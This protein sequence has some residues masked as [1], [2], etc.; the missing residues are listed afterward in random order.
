MKLIAT[1]PP[2]APHAEEI[3]EHPDVFALRFNT[4]HPTPWSKRE[5]LERLM[6]MCG[7]KPLIVDLKG[8]QLRITKWADPWYEFIELNHGITVRT[9]AVVR[10]RDH[11]SR[12]AAVEGTRLILEDPPPY[13][14]GAGQALNI[15]DPTLVIEGYLTDSDRE[16]IEAA[17]GLD[18]H[19]YLLSFLE[20]EQDVKDLVALDPNARIVAKIESRKGLDF[21]RERYE[22]YRRHI[23]LMAAR[24]DLFVNIGSDPWRMLDAQR[25]I[26]GADPRAI[27]ASRLFGSLEGH[28]SASLADLEDLDWLQRVGYRCIMLSDGLCKKREPFRNAVA[29]FGE[30]NR[31]LAATGEDADPHFAEAIGESP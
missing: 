30:F 21:V 26:I 14:V 1:L 24:D 23:R 20:E 25:L 10:F 11:E 17:A 28:H 5:A 6:K 31:R 3:A 16:W 13:A 22:P 4:V 2:M 7:R 12:V 9:G 15:L 8:R 18:L 19:H 27:A 29:L